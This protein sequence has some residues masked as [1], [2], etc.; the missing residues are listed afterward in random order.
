MSH[1]YLVVCRWPRNNRAG[2][3]LVMASSMYSTMIFEAEWLAVVDNHGDL[4]VDRVGSQ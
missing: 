1:Y 2:Q 4:L 3:V